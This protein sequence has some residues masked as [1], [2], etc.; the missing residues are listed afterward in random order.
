MAPAAQYIPSTS[1][2]FYLLYEISVALVQFCQSVPLQISFTIGPIQLFCLLKSSML[3]SE[4]IS[5]QKNGDIPFSWSRFKG[6]KLWRVVQTRVHFIASK[7]K[8]GKY[9]FKWA[10]PGHFFIYLRLFKQTL[11]FS[12]NNIMLKNVHPVYSTYRDPNSQPAGCQSPPITA[13]PGLTNQKLSRF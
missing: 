12:Y 3:Y 8:E 13:R 11:Q 10:I 2:F 4:L 6:H 5:K 9:F 7:W 1:T